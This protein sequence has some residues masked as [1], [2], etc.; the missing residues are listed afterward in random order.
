[1]TVGV[2][3]RLR[4][5][6]DTGAKGDIWRRFIILSSERRRHRA[7]KK[8]ARMSRAVETSLAGVHG[9]PYNPMVFCIPKFFK[10]RELH[11]RA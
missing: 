8:R 3:R 6:L 11:Q 10:E 7:A 9:F 5:D 4:M 1:M 2:G